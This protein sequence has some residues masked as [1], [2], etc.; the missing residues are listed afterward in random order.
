[1]KINVYKYDPSRDAA[2]YYVSGEI[3]YVEHMTGL[4]AI[5]RFD[6]QVAHVN[7]DHSC[8]AR[9]CGRCAMLINGVPSLA[10]VTF[11]EDKE[12][13]FEPLPGFR[14]VRDLIVDKH[15]MDDKLTDIYE[16]VRVEP[17]DGETL[18]VDR[19]AFDDQTM[20]AAYG[21]E[22]CCRCGVCQAACPIM[23]QHL[24]DFAGPAALIATA[25]RHLD[26]LDQGDRVVEAVSNGL[27][28][29][30]QCG[31]CDQVCAEEDI[32]HLGAWALLRAAAEECGI[33]PSYAK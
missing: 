13:T 9:A 6:E 16:R 27:F 15:A 1:M 19:A 18:R 17:F 14:V 2:P 25:Y 29:C 31:T 8:R 4:H 24:D 12:Y 20:M 28:R 32:D 11:L 21:I 3:D 30:I 5:M 33:V 7:F 26:P 23:A 10:C 22:Y